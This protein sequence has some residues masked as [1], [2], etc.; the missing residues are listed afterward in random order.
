[1]KNLSFR[2]GILEKKY[3][4]SIIKE[5]FRKLI[6]L[7][8]SLI[9]LFVDKI[10]YWGTIFLLFLALFIYCISEILRLSGT[11][12]PII[13]KIT[14]VAARKRDEN[15]FVLGPVTLV[16]GIISALLLWE[17]DAARIGIYALAFGDGLASLFGKLF[18]KRRIPFTSGKTYIGSITCFVAVFISSF[19]V[20]KNLL[21]SLLIAFVAMVL[22]MLPLKDFDN[23]L[24]PV[25]I[26][27]LAQFLI[28]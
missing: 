13:S 1:M 16:L 12:V 15:K 11:Q 5:V 18:G 4:N 19:C 21:Y 20:C 10:S 24:L 9:P 3:T 14:E 23:V 27:A 26:G 28:P 7:C 8:I 2:K 25:C 6:N 17:N 22:E